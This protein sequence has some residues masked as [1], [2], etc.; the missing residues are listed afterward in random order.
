MPSWPILDGTGHCTHFP[1]LTP[2]AMPGPC[3]LPQHA[4]VEGLGREGV[5]TPGHMCTHLY[6]GDL[7]GRGTCGGGRAGRHG[8]L[9][10]GMGLRL[11]LGQGLLRNH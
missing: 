2:T 8:G 1:V 5:H 10:L 3:R 9:R 11:H 6:G 4:W 7:D